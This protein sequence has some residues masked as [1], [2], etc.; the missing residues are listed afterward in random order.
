[1]EKRISQ[2]ELV[3]KNEPNW[4]VITN[5]SLVQNFPKMKRIRKFWEQGNGPVFKDGI[6][7]RNK[8]AFI[9][10]ENKC[11]HRLRGVV[12]FFKES[13]TFQLK[14]EQDLI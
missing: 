5:I 12:F 1:M 2:K 8:F 7:S 10:N 11:K 14:L 4:L 9:P 3:K 6:T 13:S